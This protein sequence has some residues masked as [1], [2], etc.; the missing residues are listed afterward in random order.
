M[1]LL[2]V[3]PKNFW[4]EPDCVKQ[5]LCSGQ[6]TLLQL[7]HD[8]HWVTATQQIVSFYYENLV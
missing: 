4:T 7:P 8:A 5:F 3:I 2:H 6:T 1:L